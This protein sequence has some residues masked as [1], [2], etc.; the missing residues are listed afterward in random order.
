LDKNIKLAVPN[1]SLHSDLKSEEEHITIDDCLA[2]TTLWN[3]QW[4]EMVVWTWSQSSLFDE[5]KEIT[6][7]LCIKEMD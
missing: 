5:Y 7:T 4:D 6:N 3:V 1:G 2:K